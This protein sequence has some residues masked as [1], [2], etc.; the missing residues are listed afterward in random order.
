[1]VKGSGGKVRGSIRILFFRGP[2]RADYKERGGGP[3]WIRKAVK[4]GGRL[5]GTNLA[6]C[7]VIWAS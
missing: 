5:W 3:E 7:H 4:K 6:D 1:M 2:S